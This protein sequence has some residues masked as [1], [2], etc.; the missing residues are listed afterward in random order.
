MSTPQH[1]EELTI[2]VRN[3]L[4]GFQS[5]GEE[6]FQGLAR[7]LVSFNH[8]DNLVRPRAGQRTSQSGELSFPKSAA[9]HIFP[10]ILSS[11]FMVRLHWMLNEGQADLSERIATLPIGKTKRG[12]DYWV[13]H[14]SN[15]LVEL[16]SMPPDFL[17]LRDPFRSD[18]IQHLTSEHLLQFASHLDT[19]SEQYRLL[20]HIYFC[21]AAVKGVRE[22]GSLQYFVSVIQY[23]VCL[24]INDIIEP[25]FLEFYFKVIFV[26]YWLWIVSIFFF[27]Q[28]L[29]HRPSRYGRSCIAL[30]LASQQGPH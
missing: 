12:I 23:L 4:E 26:S 14:V 20:S 16:R 19:T 21:A 15:R 5:P 11:L 30:G 1:F 6:E 3:V 24:V 8:W 9:Q 25:T 17:K 29:S 22:S 27:C 7:D 2:T 28:F 10:C 18:D 13:G